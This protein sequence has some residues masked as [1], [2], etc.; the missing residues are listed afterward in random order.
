VK[1]AINEAR[2][3]GGDTNVLPE[4]LT[5]WFGPDAGRPGT[6]FEVAFEPM[7]SGYRMHAL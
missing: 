1:Q 2:D 4:V 7:E 3:A 6:H 5:A